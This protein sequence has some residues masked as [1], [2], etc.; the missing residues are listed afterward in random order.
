MS[1]YERMPKTTMGR[2]YRMRMPE[3][4]AAERQIYWSTVV[5]LTFITSALMFFLWVKAV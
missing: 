4:V 1:R 5:G 3:N 2:R